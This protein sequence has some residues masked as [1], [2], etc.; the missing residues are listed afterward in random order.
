[1]KGVLVVLGVIGLILGLDFVGETYGILKQGIFG[2][3]R[4][5][6]KRQN[7]EHTKSYRKGNADRLSQLCG[8]A[9]TAAPNQQA[10]INDEIAHEFSD[11]NTS[12]VPDYLQGCLTAAR[13]N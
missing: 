11:V 10:L 7:Y 4:E 2:V 9:R 5:D 8:Q 3:A 6:V 13:A 12:D 1:M